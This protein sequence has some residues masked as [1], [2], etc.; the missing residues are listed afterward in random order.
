MKKVKQKN[1]S[2]LDKYSITT[3]VTAELEDI[4]NELAGMRRQCDKVKN[5][6]ALV[7]SY[8]EI[9]L[10]RKPQSKNSL[11]G[12]QAEGVFHFKTKHWVLAD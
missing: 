5:Y 6:S 11:R 9:S 1:V 7:K 3:F 8:I 4:T 10:R 2:E 12:K